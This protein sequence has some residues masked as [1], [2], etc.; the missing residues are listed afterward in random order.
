[1]NNE[2]KMLNI[3]LDL[4]KNFQA[5]ALKAEFEKLSLTESISSLQN[6]LNTVKNDTDEYLS[7]TEIDTLFEE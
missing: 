4:K 2:E 1:M 6:D 5:V 7:T 3:L